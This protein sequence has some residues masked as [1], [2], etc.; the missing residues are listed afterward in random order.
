MVFLLLFFVGGGG[1]P[2]TRRQEESAFRCLLGMALEIPSESDLQGPDGC[3][4]NWLDAL[5]PLN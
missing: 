2:H 3:L 5:L 1:S 4:V